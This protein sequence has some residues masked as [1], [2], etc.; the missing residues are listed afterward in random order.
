MLTT[1]VRSAPESARYNRYDSDK[2]S[3]YLLKEMTDCFYAAWE[4]LEKYR[5]LKTPCPHVTAGAPSVRKVIPCCWSC[6]AALH[7]GDPQ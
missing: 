4:T 3:P 2:S 5:V 6:C 1:S 7:Q